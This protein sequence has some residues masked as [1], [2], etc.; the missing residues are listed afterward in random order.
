M[1]GNLGHEDP[2]QE[3][4]RQ[5]LRMRRSRHALGPAGRSSVATLTLNDTIIRCAA[6]SFSTP[7]CS[8][9]QSSFL[10][11][12]GPRPAHR[13][14]ELGPARWRSISV[15]GRRPRHRAEPAEAR[16]TAAS[17]V[18]DACLKPASAPHGRRPGSELGLTFSMREVL[19][20]SL[21]LSFA[22]LHS[23][24]ICISCRSSARTA[25]SACRRHSSASFL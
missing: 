14:R 17:A 18:V 22:L 8:E 7:R 25:L 2:L 19:G 21:P 13:P 10:K 20:G 11:P 1:G 24:I 9:R 5:L 16:L 15:Q 3:D 4:H 23:L 12:R 6:S